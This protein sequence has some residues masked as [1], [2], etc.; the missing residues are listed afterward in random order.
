MTKVS[1]VMVA[2][3]GLGGVA[4]AQKAGSGAASAPKTDAK[5]MYDMKAP[6][7]IAIV[8]SDGVQR[9]AP[10]CGR[11]VNELPFAP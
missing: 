3:A 1:I 10:A 5:D 8:T 4:M 7:E 11:N 2:L 9:P 6:A